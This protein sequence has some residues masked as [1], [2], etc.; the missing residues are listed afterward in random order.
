M[1][2]RPI[3]DVLADRLDA[4]KVGLRDA[5]AVLMGQI[6]GHKY[7]DDHTEFGFDGEKVVL[8]GL[9]GQ[10]GQ[11]MQVHVPAQN[12]ILANIATQGFSARNALPVTVTSLSE[13]H[14]NGVVV[15]LQTGGA[16]LLARITKASLREMDIS[17]EKKLFCDH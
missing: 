13:T 8:S 4:S 15:V 1:R 11:Q 10:I 3:G 17:V 7:E 6:V 12:V 9:V 14:G 5:G 16:L 2:A